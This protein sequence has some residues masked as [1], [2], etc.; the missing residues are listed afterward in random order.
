MGPPGLEP[1]TYGL[2]VR[3]SAI[4]LRPLCSRWARKF[5]AR[6]VPTQAAASLIP[7][8]NIRL[9]ESAFFEP[10][11][12][13]SYIATP[14]TIGPWSAQAQ[15]GGPPS[16]LA[17]RAIEQHHRDPRQRLARVSIDILRPI[18]IGKVSVRTRTVR[19]GKR[20]A[21]VEAVMEA[22]GL[23]VLY[24]RGWRI[25]RPAGEVPVV[26]DDTRRPVPAPPAGEGKPPEIFRREHRGYL[27][28]IEWR[29]DEAD[30]SDHGGNA[31]PAARPGPDGLE[32]RTRAAWTRPRIPLLAG[33]E[34]SPMSRALLVADSGSGV[35]AVLPV[36]DFIFIN[37]DLTVVL[38]RDPAGEW[39][40]LEAV[41]TI[42][43]DGTGLATTRLSDQN[44][45][46]GSAF[47]TLLVAPVAARQAAGH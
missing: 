29:F 16:A 28:S 43:A 18:P 11:G 32:A 22:D 39:L 10:V 1:G 24:A 2:K 13:D 5:T 34:M 35:S 38:P 30:F 41:T 23:E 36:S 37:V 14:A 42:G 6:S 7:S 25:E 40:L 17:A 33:E 44:G 8:G 12:A 20:V 21:L 31:G 4:E 47:Q 26:R 9:V 27:T 46:F 45:S 15:H 3:Y 19:P